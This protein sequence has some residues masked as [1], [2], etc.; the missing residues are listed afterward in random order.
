MM[1]RYL[2]VALRKN[3]QIDFENLSVHIRE[4]AR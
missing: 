2:I 1:R 4:M 3:V